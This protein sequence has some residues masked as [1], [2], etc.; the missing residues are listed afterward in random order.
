MGMRVARDGLLGKYER[1]ES[2]IESDFHVRLEND[3]L[4]AE[5]A[6]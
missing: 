1:G 2:F 6:A 3:I 5:A 4:V